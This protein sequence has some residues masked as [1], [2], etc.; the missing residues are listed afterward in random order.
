MKKSKTKIKEIKISIV[1][2]AVKPVTNGNYG[3]PGIGL[4]DT[5]IEHG[6]PIEKTN[7]G[8]DLP[9]ASAEAKSRNIHARSRETIGCSS[10]DNIIAND[11]A[12]S[13][14][15]EKFQTQIRVYHDGKVVVDQQLCDFSHPLIQR[16]AEE[17]Y[18]ICRQK[19]INGERGTYITGNDWFIMEASKKSPGVYGLRTARMK[20]LEAM[21]KRNLGTWFGLV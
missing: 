2:Q 9:A 5:W 15:R 4:E 21:T 8:A 1:G 20:K 14:I 13:T 12:D 19:I 18:E 7:I 17:A 6:F 3:A 16:H 11:W 10:I